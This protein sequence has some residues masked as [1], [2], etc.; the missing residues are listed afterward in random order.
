MT[1]IV[2]LKLALI[3]A[4][5]VLAWLGYNEFQLSNHATKTPQRVELAEIEAERIPDNPH[6]EIGTHWRMYQALLFR[7]EQKKGSDGVTDATPIDYPYYPILSTTHPFF[8]EPAEAATVRGIDRVAY[9]QGG[10][11]ETF[12]VLVKTRQ[13]KTVGSLPEEWA[14]GEP[15]RGLV[16]NRIYNLK[17]DESELLARSFPGIDLDK[18]LVLYEGRTPTSR[19][20]VF[21][22]LGGG[23]DQPGGPRMAPVRTPAQDPGRGDGLTESHG[24]GI[25]RLESLTRARA[26][27]LGRGAA[28]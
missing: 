7:Y 26:P 24:I 23:G 15:I 21:A 9:E 4:G 8:S 28:R 20:M 22:L 17:K 1:Q 13:F 5:S 12:S 16:V 27:R 2:K 19:T 25:P 3:F 10:G 6:L 18:V 14:K 11:V